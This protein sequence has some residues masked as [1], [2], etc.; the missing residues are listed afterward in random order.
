MH[1]YEAMY[2]YIQ[3]MM[4]DASD[5]LIRGKVDWYAKSSGTTNAR[6]KYIPVTKEYLRQGHLKCA[7]DAASH[8]YHEDSDAKLFANKNLIMG[9]S[10]EKLN[11]N[12]ISGDISAIILHHFPKIGRGFYTPSFETALLSD[13][14]EKIKRT[15]QETIKEKVTLLAGIPTWTL[16][17]LKEILNITGAENI[18]QVWPDLRSYL[19]GGVGFSPYKN[20]FKKLIPDS[21]VSFREVYNASEGYFALQNNKNADGM[22]LL[23]DHGIYYEFIPKSEIDK[24]EPETIGLSEVLLHHEYELVISTISGLYRYRMGDIIQFVSINPYKIKHTGRV[25]ESINVYGEELYVGNTDKAL[26]SLCDTY[27]LTVLNYTIAPAKLGT[28]GRHEWYIE[29]LKTPD[30]LSLFQSELDNALRQINSDYDAKRSYDLVM[31]PLHITALAS[32]TFER[33][34]RDRGKYGNQNKMPRLKDDRHI[35]EELLRYN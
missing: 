34:Q 10:L 6:S 3:K 14:D 33:Y 24:D 30:N 35:V 25:Q 21:K 8:I 32:G 17:L 9:G 27:G 28:K 12:K 4:D 23:C 31:S 19:H 13:W 2:P 22:L 16:V 29:F 5:I 7:W 26:S 20:E 1:D 15:A 11:H 18:C